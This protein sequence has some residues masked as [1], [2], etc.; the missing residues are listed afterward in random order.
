[1]SSSDE[2][3]DDASS[4]SSSSSSLFTH[5]PMFEFTGLL[6]QLPI[7]RGLSMYYQG[8]SRTVTS[9]SDVRFIEDLAKREIPYKKRANKQPHSPKAFISK[10]A[11]KCPLRS[12]MAEGK[13]VISN[14]LPSDIQ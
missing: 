2:L 1:M 11:G 8:K 12:L 9:L 10:K 6:A 4:S 13:V 5:E 14:H 3:I 7:K